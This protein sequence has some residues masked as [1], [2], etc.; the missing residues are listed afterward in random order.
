[1]L[2]K[3]SQAQKDKYNIN[4]FM[5]LNKSNSKAVSEMVISRDWEQGGV[6]RDEKRQEKFKVYKISGEINSKN[7]F[8]YIMTIIINTV[9]Y[10]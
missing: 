9:L 7:V 5:D 4:L 10:T 2:N 3:I 6:E 8:Y 1:M